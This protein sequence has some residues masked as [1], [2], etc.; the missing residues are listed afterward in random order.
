M[1][2]YEE[3]CVVTNINI[4]GLRNNI[5]SIFERTIKWGEPINVVT[6]D[7]NAVIISEEDYYSLMETLEIESIPGLGDVIK[8]G[9]RT[10]IEDCVPEDKVSW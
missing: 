3:V 10:P 6:K 7:G 2:I 9:M 1:Y 5:F 4:T 8:E